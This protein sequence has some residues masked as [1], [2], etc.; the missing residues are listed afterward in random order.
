MKR[1]VLIYEEDAEIK[2]YESE[3]KEN[4]EDFINEKQKKYFLSGNKDFVVIKL[5]FGDVVELEPIQVP[6]YRIKN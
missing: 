4:M 6:I 2:Y 1:Y 3:N 5:V